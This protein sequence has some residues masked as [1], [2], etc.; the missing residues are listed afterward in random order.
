MERKFVFLVYF[1]YSY[2]FLNRLSGD[3]VGVG[4]SDFMGYEADT[5]DLDDEKSSKASQRAVEWKDE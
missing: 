1:S 2:L 3:L 5:K 4:G